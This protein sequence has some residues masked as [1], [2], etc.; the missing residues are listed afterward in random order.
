MNVT[1]IA[2]GTRG[3]V[4]P[5]LAL[6]KALQAA[7]HRVRLVVGANF[8][9]WVERHGL[10]AATT[11]VDM[12]T[13]MRSEQGQSWVEQGGN[14][15]KQVRRI[16]ELFAAY[17]PQLARDAW[18]A[19]R[20]A[21]VVISGFTSDV[22]AASMAEKLDIAHVIALLQPLLVATRSGPASTQPVFADR[23]SLINYYFTKWIV[24]PFNW[25][26][27]GTINNQL[28][29]KTLGLPPQAREESRAALRRALLVHGFSR[30]VVPPA[31]DWPP[32]VRTAGYWFLDEDDDWQ[33][34]PELALFFDEGAP[35]VYVGFGSITGSDPAV[36][37]DLIVR[38]MSDAGQRVILQAG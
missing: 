16:Q 21:D 6:G 4:Q 10:Q 22:Y 34:P 29:Q 5:M 37:T 36:L 25:R 15:L 33:P 13:M 11:R 20:D 32:N 38:A 8:Q 27:M 17:G 23:D 19:C 30:H 7:G 28:R 3:D 31:A 2:Y 24:D 35:P 1:V 14:Q 26:M 9:E 18:P 12:Q